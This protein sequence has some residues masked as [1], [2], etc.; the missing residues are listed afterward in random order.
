M[1]K[2]RRK[3]SKAPRVFPASYNAALIPG[4]TRGPDRRFPHGLKTG[5]V[6]A[7]FP[8]SLQARGKAAKNTD[9]LPAT[10]LHGKRGLTVARAAGANPVPLMENKV[11]LAEMKREKTVAFRLWQGMK[12]QGLTQFNRIILVERRNY[13]VEYWFSGPEH[14][15]LKENGPTTYLSAIYSTKDNAM[16]AFKLNRIVWEEEYP[17]AS[18]PN[19]S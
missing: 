5:G 7:I 1:A 12:R 15:F 18:P 4:R 14:F 19:S 13:R 16:L 11:R 3:R 9:P 6:F 2:R 8:A 10:Q 17:T